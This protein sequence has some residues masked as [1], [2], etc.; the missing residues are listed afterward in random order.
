M[1]LSVWYCFRT[2]EGCIE[3]VVSIIVGFQ[4]VGLKS[5]GVV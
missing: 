3:L 4:L 1:S 5:S 2:I